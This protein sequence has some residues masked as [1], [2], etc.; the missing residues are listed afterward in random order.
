VDPWGGTQK[1]RI[2]TTIV[3][4]Y[5]FTANIAGD[6]CEVRCLCVT[7]GPHHFQPSIQEAQMLQQAD[8]VIANGLGLEGF[9]DPLLRS[10]GRRNLTVIRVGETLAKPLDPSQSQPGQLI[11]VPGYKHGDHYH[12]PGF[13]PHVWLGIDEAKM[14]VA[15]IRDALCRL[16]PPHATRFT[17][18]AEAYLKQL[19]RLYEHGQKLRETQGGLVTA[20]DSWRYFARAFFGPHYM[21]RLLAIQGLQGEEISAGEIKGLVAAC[22]AK[23]VRVIATEPQYPRSTAETLAKSLSPSPLIIALDTLETAE[24]RPGAAYQLDPDWYVKRMEENLARLLAAFEGS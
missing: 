5:C 3:P 20:H 15:A 14:Q 23:K 6:D 16:D 8:L 22:V 11:E 7:K 2:L 17:A 19:N 21:D 4:L 12:P 13:D 10:S 24:Q 9:L 18:R 1:K